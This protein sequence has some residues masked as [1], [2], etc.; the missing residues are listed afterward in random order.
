[1]PCSPPHAGT[2]AAAPGCSHQ[3]GPPAPA[4]AASPP[5]PAPSVGTPGCQG[6]EQTHERLEGWEH[7]GTIPPATPQPPY[8][9]F[10]RPQGEEKAATTLPAA[11]MGNPAAPKQLCLPSPPAAFVGI[12]T[13]LEHLFPPPSSTR[14]CFSP[15]GTRV[16]SLLGVGRGAT[17]G[18]FQSDSAIPS[19]TRLSQILFRAPSTTLGVPPQTQG[20]PL[21]LH[22]FI[23]PKL[24]PGNS[25]PQ[26][27][28]MHRSA[29][30]SAEGGARPS[31]TGAP[32]N[33]PHPQ[34]PSH[35]SVA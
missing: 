29:P 11:P 24:S 25:C 26:R 5:A 17:G 10:P 9:S 21:V 16:T 22:P 2:A 18:R 1:M 8:L 35:P 6:L 34:T 20:K 31:E 7:P 19:Q 23:S 28:P 33:F 12:P 3:A 13:P 30:F 27:A 32:Q 15:S 14:G 4:A